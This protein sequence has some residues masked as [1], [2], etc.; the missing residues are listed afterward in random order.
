MLNHTYSIIYI[1]SILIISVMLYVNCATYRVVPEISD[2]IYND[3]ILFNDNNY[4]LTYKLNPSSYTKCEQKLLRKIVGRLSFKEVNEVD[5]YQLKGFFLSVDLNF[6]GY[7]GAGIEIFTAITL[8]VIP[9]YLKEQDEFKFKY[10]LFND[11]KLIHQKE[12]VLRVKQFN[13]IFVAPA[14]FGNSCREQK[15]IDLMTRDF[16]SGVDLKKLH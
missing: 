15:A 6:L 11:N 9:T 5:K 4:K 13:W 8:G 12:Y 7:Q 1:S 2:N 14:G 10:K 3:K 16:F